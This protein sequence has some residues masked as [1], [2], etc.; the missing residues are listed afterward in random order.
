MQVNYVLLFFHGENTITGVY[1]WEFT[2]PQNIFQQNMDDL[3]QLFEF[4]HAYV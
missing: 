4:I 2:N 3:F 1:Q